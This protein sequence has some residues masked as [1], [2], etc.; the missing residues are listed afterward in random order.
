MVL[1]RLPVRRS[2]GARVLDVIDSNPI[3]SL[4]LIVAA[5]AIALVLVVA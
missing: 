3:T 1:F 4:A 5:G 2:V